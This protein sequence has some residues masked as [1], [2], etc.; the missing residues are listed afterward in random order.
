MT[1]VK[2]KAKTCE[3][4]NLKESLIKDKIVSGIRSDQVRGRLLRDANLTLENAEAI[5]RATER[6]EAQLKLIKEDQETV[7]AI[8][9]SRKNNMDNKTRNLATEGNCSYCGRRHPPRKCPAFGNLCHNC[10]KRNHFKSVCRSASKVQMVTE[11]EKDNEEFFVASVSQKSEGIKEWKSVIEVQG[12]HSSYNFCIRHRCPSEYS[13][14]QPFQENERSQSTR[15]ECSSYSGQQ[16]QIM[17]KSKLLCKTTNHECTLEFQVL[18][19]KAKPILGLQACEAMNLIQR[20]ELIEDG[21]LSSFTDVFEGLG[22]MHD[23]CKIQ[24]DSSVPPVVHPPRKVPAA[25]GNALKQELQRLE[26]EEVIEKVD[27]PTEWVNSLVIVE[28]RGG[29]LRLYLDPRDLNKAIKREHYQ[30]P[31]I[32]E[33]VSRQ[34]GNKVFSVLDANSAFWQIPLDNESSLLTTFNTP[35]GRYKFLRLPFGLNSSAEIFAKRFH[36]VFEDIPG[37]ETYMDE[38]LISGRDEEE[39]DERLRMVVQAARNM[40][41]N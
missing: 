21:V 22:R 7:N 20:I 26:K 31:T 24:I 25:L 37:I 35:F 4:G 16:L 19:T 18:D 3:F 30:L 13:S 34:A 9:Y 5:C 38:I 41:S 14:V 23:T 39:H 1:A 32:E 15:F 10:G 17:G 28:K 29:G 11:E 12:R 8:N 6:S 33:I 36:Q 27:H 40:E 2:H